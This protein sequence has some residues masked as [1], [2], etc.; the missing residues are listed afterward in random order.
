MLP[1]LGAFLQFLFVVPGVDPTPATQLQKNVRNSEEAAH[2]A[3]EGR[4]NLLDKHG[5]D[6]GA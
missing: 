4:Q 5:L 6:H 2:A 3:Q 1:V